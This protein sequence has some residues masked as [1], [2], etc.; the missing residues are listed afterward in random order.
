MA[1]KE[2][3]EIRPLNIQRVPIHIVGDTPLIVHA[4]SEKAKRQ[5]LE[6]QMGVAKGKKKEA[7]NPVEDFIN[8]M[9]WLS[10]KPGEYTEAAFN[11]AIAN[12]AR[13]GRARIMV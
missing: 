9:Y 10:E 4:W 3:I 13:F 11:K 6:S 12:G 7:K 5:M 2:I 1:K 8:S